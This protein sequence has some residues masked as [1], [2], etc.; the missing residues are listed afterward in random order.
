M[1]GY[2]LIG[3]LTLVALWSG[4][5]GGKEGGHQC[6]VT[7][8][9]N[10]GGYTFVRCQEGQEELWAFSFQAPLSAGDQVRFPDSPP[11]IDFT[12]ESLNRTFQKIYF[13]PV[14]LGDKG[15]VQ[16]ELPEGPPK[17]KGVE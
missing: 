3:T 10:S 12:S 2:L 5:A 4:I 9:F 6:I 14:F 16:P 17:H 11:M 8:T 1:K 13:T 7:E 15:P